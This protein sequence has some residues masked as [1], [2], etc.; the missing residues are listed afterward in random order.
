MH[1]IISCCFTC[2]LKISGKNVATAAEL[3]I[4]KANQPRGPFPVVTYG[5]GKNAKKRTVQQSWFDSYP[6]LQWSEEKSKLL[7]HPCSVVVSI[8]QKKILSKNVED[9]FTKT[10]FLNLKKA[11]QLL[12]AHEKTLCHQECLE[13]YSRHLNQKPINAQLHE[14]CLK[15]QQLS[16]DCLLRMFTSLQY[17]ARQVS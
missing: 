2:L 8:W 6:W 16:Q 3:S 15:E 1:M 11:T 10:G 14:A 9:A 12:T 7:C 4:T 13:I 5:H 17:L